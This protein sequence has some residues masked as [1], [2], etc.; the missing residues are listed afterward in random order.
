MIE[1]SDD[2]SDQPVA[3]STQHESTSESQKSV[4]ESDSFSNSK[5]KARRL[6]SPLSD[7]FSQPYAKQSGRHKSLT[8]AVTTYLCKEGQP[9][10]TV[11]REGFRSMLK[12][13][14]FRLV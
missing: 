9:A 3:T 6:K 13:F 7:M 11:E 2:G 12:E 1:S 5:G 14:D 8:K 10:Y 4:S